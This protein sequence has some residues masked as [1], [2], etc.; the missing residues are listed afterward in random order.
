MTRLEPR[1]TRTGQ[2]LDVVIRTALL[3]FLL[4]GLTACA[5]TSTK[6]SR[7]PSVVSDSDYARVP[8]GKTQRVDDARAQLAAAS[9]ALGRAKLNS[10]DD[11]HEG[12][13]ARAD[14]A[15]AK[16]DRSRAAAETRASQESNDPGKVQQARDDTRAAQQDT[17]SADA[18][19]A[20]S[21]KLA[22]SRAAQ[23]VAAERLLAL[24]TEALDLAKL[25]TLLDAGVPAAGKYDRVAAANRV[26]AAQRA[27]DDAST[28]AA[29]AAGE[30][31]AAQG[32]RSTQEDSAGGAPRPPTP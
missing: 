27:Y 2:Q 17:L 21:K 22:T 4:A 31:A 19:L 18:R 10:V 8:A 1:S 28:S 14:Q 15:S 3:L 26:N 29:S 30:T 7:T 23:V 5:T 24:R 25:D 16:A 6:T 9:D 32:A 13:F 12:T 11:Q 20:Y